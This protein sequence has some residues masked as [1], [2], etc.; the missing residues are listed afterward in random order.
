MGNFSVTSAPLSYTCVPVGSPKLSHPQTIWVWLCSRVSLL[1]HL[2]ALSLSLS[3]FFASPTSATPKYTLPT[4]N[5]CSMLKLSHSR[6]HGIFKSVFVK[7][8]LIDFRFRFRFIITLPLRLSASGQR[9]NIIMLTND[10]SFRPCS[11]SL[12]FSLPRKSLDCWIPHHQSDSWQPH[13]VCLIVGDEGD[14]TVSGFVL[15]PLGG[16]GL[17]S[18]QSSYP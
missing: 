13:G 2:G 3:G 12:Y 7:M 9:I 1:V 6:C 15:C 10:T 16:P 8:P 4:T 5:K 11:V 17:P 18:F 14:E